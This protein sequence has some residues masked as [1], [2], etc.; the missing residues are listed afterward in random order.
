MPQSSAEPPNPRTA[1]I[2]WFHR[3]FTENRRESLGE[4]ITGVM[5]KPF[6]AG[7]Q[8]GAFRRC[9]TDETVLIERV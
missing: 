1:A 3:W 5:V 9:V 4:F 2:A 7:R 8:F 6:A